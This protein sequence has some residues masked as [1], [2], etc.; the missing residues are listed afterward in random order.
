MTRGRRLGT[1]RESLALQISQAVDAAVGLGDKHRLEFFVFRTWHQRYGRAIGAD[2]G[3]H[4]SEAAIPD[5]IELPGHETFHRGRIVCDRDE[6]YRH[7]NVGFK[8][9][10]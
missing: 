8:I 10:P 4:E 6:L 5:H 9:L 2:P 1:K 3:L 7:A